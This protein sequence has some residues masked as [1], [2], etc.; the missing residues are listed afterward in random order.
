MNS[1]AARVAFYCFVVVS[2]FG[3][4]V[5]GPL[6]V[7]FANGGTGLDSAWMGL[8]SG[9]GLAALFMYAG[10]PITCGF[11]VGVSSAGW[12][13]V[14]DEALHASQ[15]LNK[16]RS[17][18]GLQGPG[19]LLIG[20]MGA[21]IGVRAWF[22]GGATVAYALWP[23]TLAGGVAGLLIGL[24]LAVCFHYLLPSFMR[25]TPVQAGTPS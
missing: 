21:A 12:Q 3:C 10:V 18:L 20:A 4:L 1:H 7:H 14:D 9:I 23:S 8:A 15:E 17:F 16:G 24:C 22:V 6:A 25:R 19:V 2:L 11:Y 13:K 5:Y